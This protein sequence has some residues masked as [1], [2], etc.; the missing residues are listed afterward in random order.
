MTHFAAV[1]MLLQRGS[2]RGGTVRFA[3]EKRGG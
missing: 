1:F 3:K 2:L